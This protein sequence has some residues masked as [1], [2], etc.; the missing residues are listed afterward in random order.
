MLIGS[1]FNKFNWIKMSIKR[2]FHTIYGPNRNVINKI[3]TMYR[4]GSPFRALFLAV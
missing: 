3:K 1:S 2:I 4:P